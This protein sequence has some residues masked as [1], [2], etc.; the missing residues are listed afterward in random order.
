MNSR[1]NAYPMAANTTRSLLGAD[2][3]V[4]LHGFLCTTAGSM[5]IA[6]AADGSGADIVPV[7]A[8][9]AGQYIRIPATLATPCAIVLSGGAIGTLFAN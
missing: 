1:Y 3:S 4:D 2:P 7:V 5:K 8:M 6:Q 9:A